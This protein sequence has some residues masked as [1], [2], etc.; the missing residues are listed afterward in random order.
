MAE[1]PAATGF[2]VHTSS[3]VCIYRLFWTHVSKIN[4]NHT[5]TLSPIDCGPITLKNRLSYPCGLDV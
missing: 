1:R 2:L 4:K 3:S 5:H